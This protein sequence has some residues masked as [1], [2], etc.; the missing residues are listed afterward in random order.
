MDRERQTHR[1]RERKKETGKALQSTERN[2]L[3]PP[4]RGQL[5]DLLRHQHSLLQQLPR[6][7]HVGRVR[8]DADGAVLAHQRGGQ[9]QA[10]DALPQGG[11]GVIQQR[12]DVPLGPGGHLGR[13]PL[14]PGHRPQQVRPRRRVEG[15]E[16]VGLAAHDEQVGLLRRRELPARRHGVQE[17]VQ[18][19]VVPVR[20]RVARRRDDADADVL[21]QE[22]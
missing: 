17:A 19:R 22:V 15:E 12:R 9:A 16:V 13:E 21:A 1:E 2:P 6:D 5:Q 8:D 20:R 10:P 4:S 3:G 18:P 14:G 11:L 7:P